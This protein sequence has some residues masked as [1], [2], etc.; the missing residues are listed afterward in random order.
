ME[1]KRLMICILHIEDILHILQ[2]VRH[3]SDEEYEY[4][5]EEAQDFS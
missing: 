1:G 3:E 2:M 5:F 4:L